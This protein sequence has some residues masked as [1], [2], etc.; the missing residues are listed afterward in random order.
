MNLYSHL[1][2]KQFMLK[3]V[4]ACIFNTYFSFFTDTPPPIFYFVSLFK[5]YQY[6]VFYR[7]LFERNSLSIKKFFCLYRISRPPHGIR[8]R[9]IPQSPA[10]VINK[11]GRLSISHAQSFSISKP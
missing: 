1:L 9:I 11:M 6:P 2:P 8:D 7:I 5:K 10:K 4:I 3:N